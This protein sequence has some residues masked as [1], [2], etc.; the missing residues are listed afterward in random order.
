MNTDLFF[1][2]FDYLADAPN[3]VKKLREMI[4]LLAVQ[5]K[6]VPPDPNDEPASKLLE[7]IHV[8]KARLLKENK[9]KKTEPLQSV[10][11][12]EI[13][14]KLP[15]GWEWSRLAEIG[16]VNPINDVNDDVEAS[17][18]PMALISE[19]Y[20][21]SA[22]SETKVWREIKKGFTH[23]AE[24]D[25]V[26]A[27]ITPC[28]QNG[29]S[30]VMRGLKNGVG[31]GTTEL[32]VF[33]QVADTICPDYVLIYFKS[34]DFINNGIT[35]MTGSAGQKRVPKE[36]FSLNPF[37]VPPLPEQHRIVAKVDQLMALCDELETRQQKKKRKLLNLNNA[38]LDRLLI[39]RATDDFANAWR[40]LRDNFDFLYTTPE[41]IG[42]LRQ[43]ILQ[44]AVQGKLVPQDPN[45]E[46]AFVL[47]AKIKAEKARLEK[48]KKIK[49]SEPLSPISPDETPYELPKGWEWVRLETLGEVCGG[50]TPSKNVVEYWSGDI[51]WVSPKDM[52]LDRIKNTEMAISQKAV[53]NSSVRLIPTG[54]ILIVARSGILKRTLPV[55]IN[56]MEC[57][58]NQDIKVLIPYKVE[59]NSYLQILLKGFET[60]ILA[61]LVKNGMTVQS[62]M[63]S[64]FFQY[65]FPLPPL[66]EQHRIV[67]KVDQLMKLCEELEAKLIKSQTKSEKLVEAAVKAIASN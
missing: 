4:L 10:N 47:L 64:D 19:K 12:D 17:F 5:G 53:N 66:A 57:T 9:I 16:I 14:Y 1:A 43:G 62:L 56:E 11:L 28:F 15:K 59:I 34:A 46:P 35:K 58:V 29:K 45:D 36:Y 63:Y 52:K 27:K 50:G 65:L 40:L 6:L 67:T 33:R 48:E 21:K 8:E 60:L 26:L 41:A 20:G 31:A 39:A 55:S 7:Q 49:T 18:I 42:N 51:P 22:S 30:A 38:A 23:F 24:N 25:V 54:S 37:P 61:E 13:P 2:N 3:G 32:H 44:L